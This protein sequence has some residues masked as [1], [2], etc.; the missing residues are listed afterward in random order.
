MFLEK[1]SEEIDKFC[2]LCSQP[3]AAEIKFRTISFT[4]EYC[5][6]YSAFYDRNILKSEFFRISNQNIISREWFFDYR[7]SLYYQSEETTFYYGEIRN[8]FSDNGLGK[9]INITPIVEPNNYNLQQINER[10]NKILI[11]I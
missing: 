11:L 6:H 9:I 10:I 8:Y 1:F 5:L 4:C 7:V 3:L 2:P